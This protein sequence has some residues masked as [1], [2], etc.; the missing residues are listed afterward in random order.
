MNKKAVG[1]LNLAAFFIIPFSAAYFWS[2]MK[3]LTK[4]VESRLD[5]AHDLIKI[6]VQSSRF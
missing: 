1:S 2:E 5:F 6:S 3:F 4:S